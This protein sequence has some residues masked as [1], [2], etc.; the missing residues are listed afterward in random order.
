MAVG[1]CVLGMCVWCVAVL[2]TA[3]EYL[4]LSFNQSLLV[5]LSPKEC[6]VTAGGSNN[7]DAAKLHQ[8][9]SRA[10]VLLTER[11]KGAFFIS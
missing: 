3:A 6:V 5:Q 2:Y 10:G 1:V 8:V 11:K 7:A 9:I 4:P